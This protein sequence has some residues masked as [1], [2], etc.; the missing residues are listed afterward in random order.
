MAHMQSCYADISHKDLPHGHAQLS[1]YSLCTPTLLSHCPLVLLVLEDGGGE[2]QK[3]LILVPE[4]RREGG[5][6]LPPAG[7]PKGAGAVEAGWGARQ[8]RGF[9]L[10]GHAFWGVEEGAAVCS[11]Y[12]GTTVRP[13]HPP[14][15]FAYGCP[16]VPWA[17][18]VPLTLAVCHL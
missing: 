5:D 14:S 3:V 2:R 15:L 9:T 7:L 4:G 16:Y 11:P 13:C 6:S 1:P 8:A 12:P 10:A 17:F 18:T